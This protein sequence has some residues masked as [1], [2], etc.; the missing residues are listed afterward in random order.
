MKHL[1]P[2]DWKNPRKILVI[3]AHPDDPE[4][5]CGGTLTRWIDAGH[6]VNYLLLTKGD[7]GSEDPSIPPEELMKTRVNEQRAAA[8]VLGVKDITFLNYPDGF[9]IPSIEMR[10]EIV[11]HIRMLKPQIVV[12]SDPTNLFIRGIHINHPD[13]RNAGMVTLEAI[14]PAAGNHFYFPELLDEGLQPHTP[15]EVWVSLTHEPGVT[16]DI[17]PFWHIKLDALLQHKS[18]IGDPGQFVI[19]MQE[20]RVESSS[21]EN[22]IYEES[23]RRL[24]KR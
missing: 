14:F 5:F 4:F 1:L 16:I 8:N 9:V 13:H 11:R 23:F 24:Y 21:A 20:R 22:P 3:L 2:E 18:Q 6:E 15:E 12:T 19:K 17:T 7:K 10:K